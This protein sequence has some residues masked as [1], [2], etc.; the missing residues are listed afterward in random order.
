[1]R[2]L[3]A[4]EES[5]S[6]TKE[7]RKIGAECYS[8]DIKD[9]TGG[10]P[11]WHIKGCAL[12][13]AYS[14][15]YDLMI[16]HPPCTFLSVSGAC[17][18]YNKDGSINK[19]RENNQKDALNFVIKLM[20]APIKHI[21]IEN[22]ISVISTK[23]RK[24]DQII[25]PWMFGD[26]ASKS[27]CLWLKNLPNLRA[28]NIVDKGEFY[29]WIDKTGKEKKQPLWYYR[30]L[31]DAKSPEERRTLRSKSFLGIS[32]AIA[33]QWINPINYQLNLFL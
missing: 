8:C 10:H 3:I 25:H 7:F 29:T 21:A 5:Q 24:P 26:K 23:I 12:K 33:D 14:N 18:M 16:A 2:I 30:A 27:T 20:N 31:C 1:M 9:C 11:E 15:K 22:P 19:E 28:T 4:C 17:W 6:I 32:Q 13:E